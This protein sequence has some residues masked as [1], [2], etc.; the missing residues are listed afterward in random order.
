MQQHTGN[1]CEGFGWR[2]HKKTH[3]FRWQALNCFNNFN[4]S[5][6]LL[7]LCMITEKKNY[8]NVIFIFIKRVQ[9]VEIFQ[10]NWR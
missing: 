8:V 9:F 6:Y 10:Y 1:Q 7:I 4:S 3:T 2:T 5:F